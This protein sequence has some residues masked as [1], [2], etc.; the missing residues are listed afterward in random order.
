MRESFIF[1]RIEEDSVIHVNGRYPID[2]SFMYAGRK[3]DEYLERLTV[4]DLSDFY[5]HSSAHEMLMIMGT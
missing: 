4:I 5:C 3:V 2:M 1:L